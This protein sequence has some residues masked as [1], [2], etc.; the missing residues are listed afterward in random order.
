MKMLNYSATA[1]RP[2]LLHGCW[3]EIDRTLLDNAVVALTC[4]WIVLDLMFP[5]Q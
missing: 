2:K 3:C 4:A 1:V 5:L